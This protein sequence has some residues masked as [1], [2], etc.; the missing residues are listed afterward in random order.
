[1]TTL[2]TITIVCDGCL[3]RGPQV[4]EQDGVAMA[5]KLAAAIGWNRVRKGDFC[6][7]CRTR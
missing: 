4:A 6:P 5:R 2:K 7:K 1:M 3:T